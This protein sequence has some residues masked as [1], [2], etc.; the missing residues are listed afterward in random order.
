MTRIKICGITHLEDA[1]AAVSAGADALGFVFAESPRRVSPDAARDI[2]RSL[3]PFVTT[4]GVFVGDEP[5]AE[6]IADT[7]GLGALQL[8][9]GYSAPY[10]ERLSGRRLILGVRMRDES[11]LSDIPGLQHAGALLLDA[12][13]PEAAGG[14]GR[15]FD[16]E[17]AGRAAALG[18]P[19][20]VSGGLGPDNVEDAI[21]R[22]RPYGVDVASGVEASPGRKNVDKV[23]LFIER[24]RFA[25]R[26]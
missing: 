5:E 15:T 1:L 10:V 8:H 7:C 26:C 25:D 23:R 14:T 4:V 17:L 3:P 11:S 24:A 9:D 2:I 12:W 20:I 16:W 21:R 18:V 19:V 22:I 6:R 13:A